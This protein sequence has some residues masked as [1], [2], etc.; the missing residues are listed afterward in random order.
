MEAAKSL[1]HRA[2]RSTGKFAKSGASSEHRR[3]VTRVGDVLL[4]TPPPWLSPPKTSP[5][6]PSFHSSGA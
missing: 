6:L 4:G 5:L 2:Q 3:C 1:T